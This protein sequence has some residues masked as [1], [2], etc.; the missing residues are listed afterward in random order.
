MLSAI[1]AARTLVVWHPGGT[2]P[3][4]YIKANGAVLNRTTYAWLFAQ[5]GTTYGAGDGSTTFGTPDLRSEFLRGLDDGRG[6]DT[7]R[8]LGS[9]QSH[10]F[11]SHSHQFSVGGSTGGGYTCAGN[12]TSDTR[13]TTAT[14]GSETRPRN[15]AGYYCI[16]IAP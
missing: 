9:A 14:G 6:V 10:D 12:P 15:V 11:Q 8:V 16:A 2:I 5:I 7:G 1:P 13:T 3:A 4:G